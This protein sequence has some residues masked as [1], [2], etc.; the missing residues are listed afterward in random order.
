[1]VL[2]YH[3]VLEYVHVYVHVYVQIYITLSQKQLEIQALRC[4]GD[5][6]ERCQRTYVPWYTC[7]MVLEYVLEYQVGW[8][9]YVRTYLWNNIYQVWPYLI[10]G[11][12]ME[13]HGTSRF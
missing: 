7:T 10:F 5:T 6:G 12:L 4:N 8:Y 11:T 9:E 2:E 13:Y 3:G 1:M